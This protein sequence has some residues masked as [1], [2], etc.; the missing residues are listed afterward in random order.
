MAAKK[1][2][3]AELEQR[4]REI[5]KKLASRE[6][7]VERLVVRRPGETKSILIGADDG[8]P[9]LMLLDEK[10]G[11]RGFLMIAESGASTFALSGGNGKPGISIQARPDGNTLLTV[12]DGAGSGRLVLA[13]DADGS[14]TVGMIDDKKQPCAGLVSFPDD[15]PN[16]ILLPQG[17][18]PVF[19]RQTPD[20]KRER[21]LN[22][23]LR[24]AK[25]E[26]V[27]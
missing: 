14:A 15:G 3:V 10:G 9:K 24:H 16:L 11:L 4:L 23:L 19:L 21:M 25:T 5:E 8:G 26:G 13:V 18:P 2:T 17:E 1:T 7:D 20:Q 27:H 12:R 6:L 22:H